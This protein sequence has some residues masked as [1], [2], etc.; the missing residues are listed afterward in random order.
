MRYERDKVKKTFNFFERNRR[1][2]TGGFILAGLPLILFTRHGWP[3][4]GTIDRAFEYTG[5]M[6]ILAGLAGRAWSTMYIGGRKNS[7]LVQDGPYSM[8]RNPLYFFS[9]LGGL[10]A[11]VVLENLALIILYLAI[12]SFYY[13]LVIKSEEKRLEMLFGS[14]FTA[15]KEK[16]PAFLPNVFGFHSG[17]KAKA[18]P[19]LMVKTLLDGTMFLLFIP[20][21]Y[22]IERLQ[23]SGILH[24]YWRIP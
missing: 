9:F 3:E 1:I 8:C 18:Q 15:Y 20:L 24:A 13:P 14:A 10:G 7:Q 16:V 17:E 4:G 21:A 22:L 6:L 23:A 2:I 19:K 11:T 12:F 5:I